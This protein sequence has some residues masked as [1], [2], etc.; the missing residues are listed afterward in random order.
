MTARSALIILIVAL[1][2]AAGA[3]HLWTRSS[4]PPPAPPSPPAPVTLDTPVP[5]PV[6]PAI[7]HPVPERKPPAPL[8]S[9]ADSDSSLRLALAGLIER[10]AL[11]ALFNQEQ[12]V[13]HIVATVDNLPREKVSLRLLP[14]K[15]VG[16]LFLAQGDETRATIAPQ[17][18]A[19]YAAYVR[20]AGALDAKKVVATYVQYYPLFQEAYRELGY[21]R[22]YFNDRLIEVIDHLLATPEAPADMALVQPKVMYQY[23]D[24]ALEARSAG[25]KILLRIGN[26]HAA[27]IKAKLRE[28]RSELTGAQV[29]APSGG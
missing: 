12:I 4:E 23:A 10:H 11:K 27:V 28:I 2:L 29:L 20:V 19:R 9:L 8:P 6:E 24:P 5:P 3:L 7:R 1:A 15:P 25:Q 22:G 14:V 17:N 13:R 26:T 18:S 21:P 16:G